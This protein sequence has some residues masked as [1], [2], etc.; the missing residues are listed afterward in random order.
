MDQIK[1]IPVLLDGRP[2]AW[3]DIEENGQV[4]ITFKEPGLAVELM[5]IFRSDMAKGLTLGV[6][7]LPGWPSTAP[8]VY[9]HACSR[10]CNHD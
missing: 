10:E 9:G 6:V 5:S 7:F 3:A 8:N 2:L 4:T 1:S